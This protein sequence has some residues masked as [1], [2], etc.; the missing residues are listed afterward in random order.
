VPTT[1][2]LTLYINNIFLRIILNA[3]VDMFYN[4]FLHLLSFYICVINISRYI[5]SVGKIISFLIIFT[6]FVVIVL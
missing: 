6:I 2:K 5:Y 1:E 3:I 4:R